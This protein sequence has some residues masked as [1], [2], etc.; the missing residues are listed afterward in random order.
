[1]PDRDGIARL[2][3]ACQEHSRAVQP[4]LL[5]LIGKDHLLACFRTAGV[6]EQSFKYQ[7]ATGEIEGLPW[8]VETAFGYC[9]NREVKHRQIVAGGN[10]SVWLGNP[11]PSFRNY[12]GGRGGG[13][14]E[15]MARAA[16]KA[17]GVRVPLHPRPR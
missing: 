16:N 5:G 11:F 6:A 10:F 17:D 8:V 15:P 1:A 2:L 12:R 7:K 9:P 13:A 3:R 4:K 14:A